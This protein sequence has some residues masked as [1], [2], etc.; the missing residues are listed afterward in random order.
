VNISVSFFTASSG[1]GEDEEHDLER[2]AHDRPHQDLRV[3]GMIGV[4]ATRSDKGDARP[5]S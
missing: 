3:E 2:R 4:H 5:A 1:S